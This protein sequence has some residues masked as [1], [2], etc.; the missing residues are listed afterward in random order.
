MKKLTLISL[1]F[2]IFATGC[3]TTTI[4]PGSSLKT[5]NKTIVYGE[6]E[7]AADTNLNSR[8]A[9]FPITLNLIERMREP[10]VT[11]QPNQTLAQQKSVYQYRFG[12]GDVLNIMVWAHADLNSPIQQS[13]PQD[14]QVSRGA[15]VDER[16][17]ISYPLIGTIYAK[18]KTINELQNILTSRLR[19]YLKNPQ[20]VIN[21]TEFRSQRVSVAGAVKQ[22]GQLPI[23]NIPMTILDAINQAGGMAE[24]ADTQN[25]KW[26]HNGVDRT[27]SLQNMLQ[28]GDMS[29]NHMLSNGDIVYV[30]NISNSKVYIMG[31]VGRQASLPIGN[32]GLNLT[33]A[34]GDVGGMNQ[35]YADATGVFVIRRAPQDL[36]KPIHVYQLNLRDATAYALGSEF[37]LRPEDVI[38]VTAAPVARWH[39]VVSLITNSVSNVNTLDNTFGN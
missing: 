34:L 15:W 30:P 10:A 17:Y 16:G 25:I 26:T 7:T 5:R 22:A 23:T 8:V 24:N 18:G 27:V 13:S 19:R 20:V 2:I 36:E 32:H 6:N 21:V 38:Y 39:R 29:Q 14:H 28:Y 35:N 3:S 1:S 31:E 33:Q 37:K 4:I 9:V 11:A 12:N